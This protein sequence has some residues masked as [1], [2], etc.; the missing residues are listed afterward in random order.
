LFIWQKNTQHHAFHY[1][2]IR[3]TLVAMV[4]PPGTVSGKAAIRR[5]LRPLP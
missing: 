1:F 3:P 2:E 5:S 4:T